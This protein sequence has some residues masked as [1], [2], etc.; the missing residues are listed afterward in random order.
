LNKNT[1]YKNNGMFF[2]K[3]ERVEP[4]SNGLEGICT[5]LDDKKPP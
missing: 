3:L 4:T 5:A 2:S 1:L